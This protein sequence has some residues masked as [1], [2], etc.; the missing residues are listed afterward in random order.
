MPHDTGKLSWRLEQAARWELQDRLFTGD[1]F[2]KRPWFHLVEA[3]MR[4]RNRGP[5]RIMACFETTVESYKPVDVPLIERLVKP[6]TVDYNA[7]L[8]GI[9]GTG[10]WSVLYPT[11]N[12]RYGLDDPEVREYRVVAA[13]KLD[14][15]SQGYS[16]RGIREEAY[17]IYRVGIDSLSLIG[18]DRYSR[19]GCTSH[20]EAEGR[21]AARCGLAAQFRNEGTAEQFARQI[22]AM[23]ASCNG[24]RAPG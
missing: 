7:Y 6:T 16:T 9:E 18:A 17:K 1:S 24:T 14:F 2:R 22:G 19:T 4:K 12:R 15:D 10:L 11:I 3:Y 21:A 23:I 13:T 5:I 8:L 20:S